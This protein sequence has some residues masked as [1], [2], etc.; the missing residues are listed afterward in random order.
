[1]NIEFLR[2]MI[3]I[4][5]FEQKVSEL[6]LNG[7]IDGPV[8]TYIGQEAIATGV[9]M[10]LSREDYIIGNHRSHG[11]LLA[12][13]ADV[14]S[15][16]AEI[17]K[18]NGRSMHVSDSS[19]GAICSTA[20]V[21]SGLPLACGVAF[22][23]KFKKNNRVTCVFLGDGAVNEGS[24]Y[25]SINLASLW[26]LPVIF[27]IENNGVAVTT[28]LNNVSRN[29]HLFHRADPFN[30]YKQQVDGQ[31][32]EE[33]FDA[34]K[35]AIKKAPAIIEAKTMRFHEHQE[36]AAYEKMK[37][38]AYR[39]NNEVDYWIENKD[40]IKLY[41]E[42]LI[43]EKFVTQSEIEDICSEEKE[44]VNN[45]LFFTINSLFPDL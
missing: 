30:I 36:G 1:M 28:T 13:G 29:E 8:H 4:R 32:V 35:R 38:T 25:E 44:C 19:I 11:H 27:V 26:K 21:G 37:D 31:D 2:T 5:L 39:C 17:L 9:C 41:S 43:R 16:L 40:P 33:V 22:A 20:I 6:K 7:K 45:A 23:N 18:G 14:R 34:V 10:A 15:L 42:K 24:F 12:K 3:R